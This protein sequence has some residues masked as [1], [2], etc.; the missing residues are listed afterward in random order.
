MKRFV[1][2]MTRQWETLSMCKLQVKWT[3]EDI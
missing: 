2:W 1:S 3:Q